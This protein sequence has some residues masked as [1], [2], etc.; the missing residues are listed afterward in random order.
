MFNVFFHKG[1]TMIPFS[2]ILEMHP[3]LESGKIGGRNVGYG[4]DVWLT[5]AEGC[6]HVSLK[7]H[8]EYVLET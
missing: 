6:N 3:Y 8:S 2:C 5:F 1:V 7:L 4:E